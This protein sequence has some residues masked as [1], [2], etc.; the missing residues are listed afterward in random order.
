MIWAEAPDELFGDRKPCLDC[1]VIGDPPI[2][3]SRA[4]E[5]FQE[6]VAHDPGEAIAR[7][8][9]A[10]HAGSVFT[11]L[12]PSHTADARHRNISLSVVQLAVPAVFFTDLHPG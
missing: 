5:M 11:E 1:M 10:A 4:D 7:P 3:T 9:P 8:G 2:A 6:F 12:E